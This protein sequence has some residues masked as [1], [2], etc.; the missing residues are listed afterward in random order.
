MDTGQPVDHPDR[1]TV[2]LRQGTGPPATVSVLFISMI[3]A[4]AAG[5][6]VLSYFVW[7]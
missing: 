6:I 1:E 7:R 3:L 2:Q 4:I 5:A